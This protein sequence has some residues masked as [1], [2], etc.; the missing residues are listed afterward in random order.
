VHDRLPELLEGCLL[1]HEGKP[2]E[3]ESSGRH[4]FELAETTDFFI[5][6]A[7]A[8]L[9]LSTTL[10]RA[11]RDVESAAVAAEGLAIFEAKGDVT[12]RAWAQRLLDAAG[13]AA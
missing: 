8:R 9:H 12:G 7:R 4:A 1:S 5:A 2:E 13:V 11:G 10:A 6:R 3:A